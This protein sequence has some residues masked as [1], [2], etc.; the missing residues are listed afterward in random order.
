MRR[1]LTRS[2]L[3]FLSF[4]AIFGS[5]WL[6]APL[7]AAQ[8]AGPASLVAWVLGAV[9]S[10]LIGIT[11]AEVMVLYPKTGGLAQI[12]RLTHGDFLSLV[13][14]V[15]NLLVFMILPAIEVRATLQYLS[16]Y[17]TELESATHQISALGYSVAFL[18]LTLITGA[19]LYG[20]R[21]TVAL[22]KFIVV[23][24]VIT[25]IF[26]CFSFFAV[27]ST[28]GQL[29]ISNRLGLGNAFSLGSVPWV[30]VFQAIATSGII[31]SFN[32]FNQATI[33]AGEA[34]NPQKAIPFAII[35]SLL[36][37]GLLY[38][39]IQSAFLLAVPK[40]SL[41]NGW[42][43]LSFPGDQG[44]FAG[45]ATLLGLGWLLAMIYVDAVISPL[46]TAFAYASAAPRL[47]FGLA[48]GRPERE[49]FFQLNRHGVSNI[50]IGITLAL[51][52]LAFAFLPSLKAMISL[53]V[54]AFVLCY[55]TAPASL[56]KLRKTHP[57]FPRPFRV[58][59]APVVSFA[60]LMFSNLMVYSCGWAALRNLVGLSLAL[61][62]VCFLNP[63]LRRQFRGGAWFILQLWGIAGLSYA[64]GDLTGPGAAYGFGTVA[65]GV[66][67]ISGVALVLSQ[68]TQDEAR[69]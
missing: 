23:L 5:G 56:L 52:C 65:L 58:Y 22:A 69:V 28:R 40:E 36:L 19:N 34:K 43:Q 45:I 18:L 2:N 29:D 10:M 51:E 33:F 50:S 37:S 38:L 54:G 60:S 21:A 49:R 35:G 47:I 53:L 41:V 48:E 30:P 24:K 3:L 27:L 13:L 31:F 57:E 20:T 46:G 12:A 44:P 9:I 17:F 66:A 4:A 15:L 42:S 6:F 63:E 64:L 14:V 1:E 68:L 11:M 61:V 39:M 16:S 7:Y 8:I 59:W 62:A 25:P 55:T 32:G 26:V 67:F